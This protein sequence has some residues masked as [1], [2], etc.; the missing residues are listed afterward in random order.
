MGGRKD[1]HR[2]PNLLWLD[3][4][5]NGF[6]ESD[7][8]WQAVAKAWG[9]KISLH[10]DP[11]RIPVFYRHEHAWFVLE[12]D[13]RRPVATTTALEMMHDFYGDEYFLWKAIADATSRS[14]ALY[15]RNVR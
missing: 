6:I 11:E 1:K 4:L 12:G 15:L 7:A 2:L 10:A 14:R 13:S 8:E 3:S 5:V 9:V